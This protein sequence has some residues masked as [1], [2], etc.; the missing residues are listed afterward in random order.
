MVRIIAQR[1]G[2]TNTMVDI[3]GL[4]ITLQ[5]KQAINVAGTGT[6]A[7]IL[8]LVRDRTT[9]T[10]LQQDDPNHLGLR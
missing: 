1:A 3:A 8:T 4:N 6:Q 5:S 7:E 9:W 2:K 10:V